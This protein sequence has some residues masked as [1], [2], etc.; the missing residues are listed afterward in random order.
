[1]GKLGKICIIASGICTVWWVVFSVRGGGVESKGK[2]GRVE[3]TRLKN[4][5]KI[6][7]GEVCCLC[8]LSLGGLRYVN[9][10]IITFLFGL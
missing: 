1:M 7:S 3:K 5:A 6:E 2:D 4:L 10:N 8:L 9:S